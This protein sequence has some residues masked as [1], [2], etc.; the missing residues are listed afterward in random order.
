[1][2]TKHGPLTGWTRNEIFNGSALPQ[3]VDSWY[4]VRFAPKPERF[5]PP[6]DLPDD[7]TYDPIAR[8]HAPGCLQSNDANATYPPGSE[9]CLFLDIQAPT[10]IDFDK[11]PDGLP[12]MFWIY[13]GG[14][15]HGSSFQ[16]GLYEAAKFV[17]ERNFVIVKVN[18]RLG[19]LG[20]WASEYLQ[21]S[22]DQKT[23]GNQGLQ[24]QRAGMKWVQE[25][26]RGFGGNPDKVT[27]VGESA[28]GFS[29]T[30]HTAAEASFPYYNQAIIQ[31][32]TNNNPSFFQKAN[33]SFKFYND[34][35]YSMN[36]TQDDP[37]EQHDCLVNLPA[38]AFPEQQSKNNKYLNVSQSD[39]SYLQPKNVPQF[40]SPLFPGFSFGPTID[41]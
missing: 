22:N 6:T 7:F 33:D 12:V 17:A 19:A 20:F 40:A 4:G 24:D 31:S 34:F 38:N 41:G 18:Y 8:S 14:W 36:C 32:G 11:F 13:G 10:N 2:Q 39:P 9:D 29:V 28:G 35:A 26:I 3:P 21:N 16:Q 5:R 15:N 25:N 1:M 30:Y 23:T 27:I 37:K